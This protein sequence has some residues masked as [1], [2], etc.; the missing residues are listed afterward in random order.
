MPFERSTNKSRF[1]GFR[2][3]ETPSAAS[4]IGLASE[5]PTSKTRNHEKEATAKKCKKKNGL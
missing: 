5:I 1:V 3:I 2:G 4:G